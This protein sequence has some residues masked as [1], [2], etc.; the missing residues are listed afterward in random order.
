MKGA[1]EHCSDTAQATTTPLPIDIATLS[2][3][4]HKALDIVVNHAFGASQHKQLLM[5]VLG[6][7]GTGKSYL[8]TVFFM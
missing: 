6:T 8:I 3:K 4:Q 2:S 7:A 5:I 1:L